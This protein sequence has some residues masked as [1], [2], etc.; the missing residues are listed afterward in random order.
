VADRVVA[1]LLTE[2]DGVEPM[3]DVVVLGATNRPELIDPALLRPGRLERRVYVPPPDADARTEILRAAAKNTPLSSDVDLAELAGTLDGYSAAD[4]AAL[5]REAAL[6]AMRESLEA[7][8]V[9]SE[10]VTKARKAV[11]ASLDPGQLAQLEAY[12]KSR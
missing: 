10:H 11:R 3:R 12:A 5:V 8:E 1:A 2:L 6:T 9:T 7:T 4:C